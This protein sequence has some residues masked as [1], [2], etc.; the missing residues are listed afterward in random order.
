MRLRRQICLEYEAA[1]QG[2]YGLAQ[3]TSQHAFITQR[4]ENI[5]AHHVALKELLGEKAIEVLAE[6]LEQAGNEGP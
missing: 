1:Q 3:G 2:L 4:L 5:A 6:A